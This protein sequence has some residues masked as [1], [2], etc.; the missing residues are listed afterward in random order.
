MKWTELLTLSA[1]WR[2]KHLC[3]VRGRGLTAQIAQGQQIFNRLLY[4]RPSFTNDE[5]IFTDLLAYA[6]GMN[7]SRADMLATIEAEVL[8][9]KNSGPGTIDPAAY[10]D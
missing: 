6:P 4:Q 10:A 2:H 9:P 5:R 8:P 7:T 1:Y 3:A